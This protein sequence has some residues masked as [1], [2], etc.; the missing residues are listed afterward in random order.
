MLPQRWSCGNPA[1][2]PVPPNRAL[3]AAMAEPATAVTKTGLNGAPTNLRLAAPPPAP[4]LGLSEMDKVAAAALAVGDIAG[5]LEQVRA[6]AEALCGHER[7]AAVSRVLA[8]RIASV[9]VAVELLETMVAK[10]VAGRD[11]EALPHV[12]RLLRTNSARMVRLLEALALHTRLS[13]RT[14]IVVERSNVAAR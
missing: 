8:R 7:D 14:P 4:R 12:E 11:W 10:C 1:R 2:R 9:E 3:D 6:R 5:L 13:T